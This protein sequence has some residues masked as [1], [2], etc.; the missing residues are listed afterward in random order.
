MWS[1][2]SSPSRRL[3]NRGVKGDAVRMLCENVQRKGPAGCGAFPGPNI[4]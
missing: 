4:A 3:V 1:S 2:E